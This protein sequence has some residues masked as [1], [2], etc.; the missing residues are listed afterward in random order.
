MWAFL[1]VRVFRRILCGYREIGR[2]LYDQICA[3]QL[4]RHRRYQ[5]EERRGT[6]TRNQEVFACLP[7]KNPA[8]AS[9]SAG[10]YLQLLHCDRSTL[11]AKIRDRAIRG[12]AIR[13]GAL[14]LCVPHTKTLS[15]RDIG[16]HSKLRISPLRRVF[17][18]RAHPCPGIYSGILSAIT[19]HAKFRRALC[20]SLIRFTVPLFLCSLLSR[21]LFLTSIHYSYCISSITWST[22]CSFTH[23]PYWI[24]WIYSNI[25]DIK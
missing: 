9:T 22:L 6:L 10:C 2:D 7:T 13:S 12:R 24:Y 4:Q 5:D 3:V 23:I 21:T 15:T 18:Q 14:S 11:S 25:E 17:C 8:N 16:F 19:M 20:P 1:T